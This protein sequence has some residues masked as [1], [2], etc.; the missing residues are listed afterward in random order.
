MN[1]IN[2]SDPASIKNYFLKVREL[3][4]SGN[5]FPVNLDDVFPLVYS[6]RGKA[7]SHLRDNFIEN[8]D[9][10]IISQM[11]KNTKGRN[12]Y[13]YFLS[14]SAMEFFVAK[15]VK[16]VFEVYRQVFHKTLDEKQ[17]PLSQLEIL[18]QSA[19]ILL[20]QDQRISQ[21]ES[22]L[23]LIE[24]NQIIAKEELFALP[25]PISNEPIPEMSTRDKIRRMVNKLSVKLNLSQNDIW[26]R[27][28]QELYYT[29]H[30][31]IKAKK[32][33][34][35]SESWLDVADRTGNID[36]MYIVVSNIINK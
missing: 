16:E 8:E 35:K 10:T 31:S 9:Y 14:V 18:A 12:K 32:K 7:V 27:V 11:G 5:E 13:E 30:V 24:E 3:Q 29:Y 26:N 34:S 19:Q 33:I 1:L 22:K 28:Y 23:N 17:K 25:F 6:Q 2:I 20:Q 21:I 4:K 36:K 15:K